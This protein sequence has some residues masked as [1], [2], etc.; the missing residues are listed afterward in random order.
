MS[1]PNDSNSKS[2]FKDKA[3]LIASIK[4]Y[5]TRNNAVFVSQGSRISEFFEMCCFND[6]VEFYRQQGFSVLPKQLGKSGEFVYKLKPNGSHENFSYFEIEKTIKGNPWKFQVHHNLPLECVHEPGIFYVSDIAVV[7]AGAV[8]R[9]NVAV[10]SQKRSYCPASAV[11]T[12]FE[13][14]HMAPFPELLF[15]FTGIILNFLVESVRAD[16]PTHIAPAVLISGNLNTHTE[17]ISTF[18]ST[19][20]RGNV[21]ASLFCRPSSIYS[22]RYSKQTIGSL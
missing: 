14:K 1:S 9:E 12:F 16:K 15:S 21:I 7:T 3:L 22:K 10:Y 18:V 4:A 11:Q 6:V 20:Y 5:L 2:P 8:K 19:K 13:V 17:K